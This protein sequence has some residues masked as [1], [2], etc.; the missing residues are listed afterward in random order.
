M[1]S[2]HTH[3]H[4]TMWIYVPFKNMKNCDTLCTLF[5]ST[6]IFRNRELGGIE[7]GERN[8]F[9]RTCK[10]PIL[11]WNQI[12]CLSKSMGS[13][14]VREIFWILKFWGPWDPQHSTT[15]KHDSQFNRVGHSKHVLLYLLIGWD[16]RRSWLAAHIRH[17][18]RTCMLRLITTCPIL[19]FQV[20]FFKVGVCGEDSAVG[21]LAQW[22]LR[23]PQIAIMQPLIQSYNSILH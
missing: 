2:T 19:C 5:Y 15:L 1:R 21:N 10:T 13:R 4:R 8:P 20:C 23:T 14:R 6:S 9:L 16:G 12:L 11:C 18:F 17:P 7:I 3:W 22:T